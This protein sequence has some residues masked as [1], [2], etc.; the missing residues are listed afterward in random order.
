LNEFI[1]SEV[2]KIGSKERG[3]VRIS[4]MVTSKRVLTDF[5]VEK[6]FS[7]ELEKKARQILLNGPRWI[8]AKE[9]GQEP[10]D[11]FGAVSFEF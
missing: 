2:K 5:R 4:F 8:P 7:K 6:S 11:G 3:T 9:H 1:V 10:V